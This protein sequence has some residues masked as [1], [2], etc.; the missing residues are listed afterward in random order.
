MSEAVSIP[1]FTDA[2]GNPKP[3]IRRFQRQLVGLTHP[4]KRGEDRIALARKLVRGTQL[5]LV[6]EPDN[7]LDRNAILIYSA[8]DP[9]SDIGYLDAVGAR[10]FCRKMECGGKFSAEVCWI[11][12]SNPRLP[13]VYIYVFQLTEPVRNRR[14]A[15]KNAPNYK[16]VTQREYVPNEQSRPIQRPEPIQ[17]LEQIQLPK[18]PHHEVVEPEQSLMR[19]IGWLTGALMRRLGF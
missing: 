15:R 6:P 5:L 19:I 18:I 7:P 9:L 13:K 8:D 10:L 17:H 3:C 1:R 12:N 16:A 4:N 11:E 2:L 14:P